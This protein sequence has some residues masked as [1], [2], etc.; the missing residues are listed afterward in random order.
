[1]SSRTSYWITLLVVLLQHGCFTVLN[2]VP[3]LNLT[4]KNILISWMLLT[5]KIKSL[6]AD[7]LGQAVKLFP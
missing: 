7:F 6:I 2:K 1:M 4:G 5:P 3:V